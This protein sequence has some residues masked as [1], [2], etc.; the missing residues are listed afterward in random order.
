MARPP[1]FPAEEKVRI[2]LSILAERD[3]VR[4]DLLDYCNW[5]APAM[6][7]LVNASGSFT[8]PTNSPLHDSRLTCSTA[9]PDPRHELPVPI[10]PVQ[11][12]RHDVLLAASI[13]RAKGSIQSGLIPVRAGGRHAASIIS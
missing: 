7:R 13:V 12:G 2:V 11:G 9:C 4:R 6:V 1:V 8:P 3:R 10:D 5:D